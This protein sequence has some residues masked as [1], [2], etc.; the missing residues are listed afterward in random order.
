MDVAVIPER[1]KADIHVI[2]IT[3]FVAGGNMVTGTGGGP[4]AFWVSTVVDEGGW[5]LREQVHRKKE[6]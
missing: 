1:R 5:M 2:C 3:P 6:R 4:C